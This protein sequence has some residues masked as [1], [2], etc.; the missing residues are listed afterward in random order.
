MEEKSSVWPLRS[1]ALGCHNVVKYQLYSLIALEKKKKTEKPNLWFY[2]HSREEQWVLF[3]VVPL[4][5]W[6]GA[7]AVFH[8]EVKRFA[9]NSDLS[10]EQNESVTIS[11]S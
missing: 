3:P 9:P 1:C 10:P 11:L 2:S 6:G 4:L 5:K 8:S 7:W